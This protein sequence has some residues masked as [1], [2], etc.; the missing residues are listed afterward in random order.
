MQGWRIFVHACKMIIRNFT[1]IMRIGLV[2]LSVVIATYALTSA[3]DVD[4]VRWETGDFEG[5]GSAL[6][7]FLVSVLMALWFIV[8]W[9]RFVL[10]EDYPEGWMPS[11]RMDRVFSYIGHA[12]L[13]ILVALVT[14][15]PAALVFGLAGALGPA[16]VLFFVLGFVLIVAVVVISYRVSL[17]LPGAAI[18]SGLTM[19]QAWEATKGQT[20]TFLLLAVLS[21]V[22]GLQASRWG[23]CPA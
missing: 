22:V 23:W 11:F 2:P 21:I 16:G 15:V 7:G 19:G 12:I 5:A 20:G 8:N 4:P 10:L 14:T 1:P 18:G 3:P 13:V 6:L 9:H 17:L